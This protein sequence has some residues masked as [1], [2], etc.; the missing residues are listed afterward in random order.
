MET[1]MCFNCDE[2]KTFWLLTKDIRD[3]TMETNA[4]LKAFC[5]AECNKANTKNESH[6]E[7]EIHVAKK[8]FLSKIAMELI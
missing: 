2:E 4:F 3:G 6:S 1:Q 8:S 5:A 7:G